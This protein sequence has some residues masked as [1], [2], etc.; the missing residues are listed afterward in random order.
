M[1]DLK[2]VAKDKVVA[3]DKAAHKVADL[4]RC[5]RKAMV[6]QKGMVQITA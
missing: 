6:A 5:H 4:V 3:K 2:A 1:A